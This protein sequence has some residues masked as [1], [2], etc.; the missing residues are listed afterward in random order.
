V[1]NGDFV[2][3]GSQSV[4]ITFIL[5]AILIINPH[6]IV[7]NRGNHEDHIMNLRYGFIKEIMVKYKVCMGVGDE[8]ITT[9]TQPHAPKLTRLYE[10]VFA[11]LPLCTIIDDRVF[12]AHGGISDSTDLLFLSKL[13]RHNVRDNIVNKSIIIV[14][15]IGASSTRHRGR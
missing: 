8:H 11:W 4:E 7:L 6:S 9:R 3:R 14:V 5:F 13:D 15:F 1:F 2:D 10:D 12:V